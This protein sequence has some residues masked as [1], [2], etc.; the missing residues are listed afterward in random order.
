MIQ[1]KEKSGLLILMCYLVYTFAC[2]GKYCVSSNTT[3]LEQCYNVDHS[4]TGLVS[5][6]FFF[7]YG[8][9]QVINGIFCKRYNK[10]LIISGALIISCI[11]NLLIFFQLPFYLIKYLWLINGIVQS[12]LWTS[13]VLL[14]SQRLN[15]HGLAKAVLVMGMT[16]A[17]GKLISIAT[18]SLFALSGTYVWSFLFSSTCMG[19]IGVSWFIFYKNEQPILQTEVSNAQTENLDKDNT[20]QKAVI[21]KEKPTISFWFLVG[22]LAIF[23]V[24]T[25]LILEGLNSWT[26]SILKA[27]YNL[28]DS[29]SIILSIILPLISILSA[30][31]A[32]FLYRVIKNFVLELVLLMGLCS[33]MIFLVILGLANWQWVLIV[34]LF[35]FIV[36]SMHCCNNVITSIMPMY[37][38]NKVNSG[39]LAGVLNGFCYVGSTI[40]GYGLGSIA[41]NGGWGS[42]F[43]LVLIVAISVTALA[44]IYLLISKITIKQKRI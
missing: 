6:M 14:L 42:M 39:A 4:Q 1:K 29:F 10:K 30:V 12:V 20:E 37:S 3:L 21:A 35:A 8:I 19:I 41:E 25:N 11:I 7:A 24:C 40:S 32:P 38:R 22:I 9:G 17:S 13:L 18:S 33:A 43:N 44:L 34:V 23:G 5:S 27:T 28:T 36:L 16:T 15:E 26:P 2:V 31:V